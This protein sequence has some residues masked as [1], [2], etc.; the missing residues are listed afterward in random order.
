MFD[1]GLYLTF[2]ASVV[3]L[4]LTPGPVIALITSTAARKGKL[5]ALKTAIGTNSA[6][7]IL[8]AI[9]ILAICGVISINQYLIHVIG[10]IGA[11]YI[12]YSALTQLLNIVK[13]KSGKTQDKGGY[14]FRY[15]FIIA[16]SNPKD[17]FFFMS[18]FP[19]FTGIIT[20]SLRT[21]LI[22]LCVSWVILDLSILSI[23]II[24]VHKISSS[25]VSW[26]LDLVSN[27]FLLLIGIVALVYNIQMTGETI[28]IFS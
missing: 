24:L 3:F 28:N 12:S 10:V 27:L 20:D 19:Q 17:V 15:G 5:C 1:V 9:A 21:S 23:Y 14:G 22:V 4:L 8:I 16:I 11:G 6:S 13:E 2:I 25:K 26:V 7:L 18:F